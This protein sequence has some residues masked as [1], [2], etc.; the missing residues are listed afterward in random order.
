MIKN[1]VLFFAVCSAATDAANILAIFPTASISHQLPLRAVTD[2]LEDQGHTLTIIST[3]S[4]RLGRNHPNT[5]EIDLNFTYE[6]FRKNFNFVKIK[7]STMD[8]IGMMEV[9]LPL[10]EKMYKEQFD[11]PDV[12]KLIGSRGNV[13][14]DVVLVEY[15]MYYPWFAVAEWFDAPLIGI[16]S[17]DTMGDA[18]EA[19]GNV[20][21][22]IVHPEFMLP[23]MECTTIF[24]RYRAWRFYFWYKFSYLSRSQP[25]VNT[26]IDQY[27]PGTEKSVEKL[28]R[29]ASLLM[30][31]TNPALGFIRPILPT[32]VQLGFL[33]IKPPKPLPSSDL[34]TFLDNSKNGVIYM[35]LGSNVQSS[36]MNENVVNTFLNVFKTL[37][38]NVVWKW[39]VDT[40]KNKPDNVFIQKWMPQADLLAHPNIKMFITQGGHQS[41]EEAIDRTVPLIVIPFLGDQDANA[42][43]MKKLK[44]GFYLE[45]N[46]LSDENLRHAINEVANGDFE[47]NI[48]KLRE[49]VYDQPMTSRERAVWWIEYVIRHKGTKHIEYIGK[50]IPFYQQYMLDFIGIFLAI[51]YVAFKTLSLLKRLIFEKKKSKK[52]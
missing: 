28:V 5:T 12:K 33:H 19:H 9:F 45:L 36:E 27:M 23:F 22:P 32:T 11:H 8:E 46:T 42:Q 4:Q 37:P 24:Q 31:N 49:L 2:A 14:F 40:M 43:R 48:V 47:A 51:A 35:S 52:E 6:F 17:L 25:I 29:K 3:D 38:Y 41:M 13:T 21:H 34:K 1:L 16:T 26:L 15:L 50:H 44:I 39:E 10:M 7:E 20:F 18:H 30:T